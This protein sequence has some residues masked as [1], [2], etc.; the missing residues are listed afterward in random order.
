MTESPTRIVMPPPYM[1]PANAAAK[2][3]SQRFRQESIRKL[4][5]CEHCG[6]LPN[7]QTRNLPTE[8]VFVWPAV[9]PDNSIHQDSR[10]FIGYVLIIALVIF[11]LFAACK[12]LP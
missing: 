9:R 7:A 5:V 3:Q 12:Y 8:Q 6:A 1:D 4:T 11:A 2:K 10:Q